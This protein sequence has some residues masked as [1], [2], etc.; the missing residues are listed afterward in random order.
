MSIYDKFVCCG[1]DVYCQVNG[2][3]AL[4]T[5]GPDGHIAESM[6][7]GWHIENLG[8]D[9]E[10][11]ECPKCYLARL[12]RERREINKAIEWLKGILTEGGRSDG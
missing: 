8:T 5:M 9:F 4:F 11:I 6:P 1:A 3:A 7:E 12:K 10:I 2:C